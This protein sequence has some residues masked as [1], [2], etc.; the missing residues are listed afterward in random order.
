MLFSLSRCIPLLCNHI[1]IGRLYI[2]N[3]YTLLLRDLPPS[4]ISS[5]FLR[6]PLSSLTIILSSHF[7]ILF[8]FLGMSYIIL[9]VP[10]HCRILFPLR[11]FLNFLFFFCFLF[12][13]LLVFFSWIFFSVTSFLNNFLLLSHLSH[14]IL[15]IMYGHK[16][17]YSIC[18]YF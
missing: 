8:F 6:N 12:L 3:P 15:V 2:L 17:S 14:R 1:D 11:Y 16:N 10:P 9:Y 7:S 5:S 13:W 4:I 18:I